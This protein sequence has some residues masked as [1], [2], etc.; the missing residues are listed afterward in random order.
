V[1][2]RTDVERLAEYVK[3]HDPKLKKTRREMRKVVIKLQSG[4]VLE[5]AIPQELG[6]KVTRRPGLRS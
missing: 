6:G 2:L 3:K 4:K 5:L 1:Y